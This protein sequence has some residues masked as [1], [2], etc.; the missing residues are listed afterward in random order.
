MNV[1][2][3]PSVLSTWRVGF[4]GSQCFLRPV[5]SSQLLLSRKARSHRP[6]FCYLSLSLFFQWFL[7]AFESVSKWSVTMHT[8]RF[9]HDEHA[10]KPMKSKYPFQS[11]HV[12][13]KSRSCMICRSVWHLENKHKQTCGLSQAFQNEYST[14]I[15]KKNGALEVMDGSALPPRFA[16]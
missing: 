5:Q 15:S 4:L 1:G 7:A 10:T 3:S 8:Q 9:P 12:K 2:W 6:S 14:H 16:V 11:R 13:S